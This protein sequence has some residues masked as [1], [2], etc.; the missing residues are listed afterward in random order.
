MN[1]FYSKMQAGSLLCLSGNKQG[2]ESNTGFV[3]QFTGR[4]TCE[5]REHGRSI[6]IPIESGLRGIDACVSFS[7]HAFERWE[8]PRAFH[9]TST[10]EQAR[11]VKNLK[12][13]LEF[14]GLIVDL[15]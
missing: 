7:R 5:H 6:E 2:V 9:E 13:A 8:T 14:Q 3:V 1:W 12:E 11:L 15:L 4:F 10:E